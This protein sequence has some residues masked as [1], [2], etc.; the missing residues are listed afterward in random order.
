VEDTNGNLITGDNGRVI[1]VS[2]GSGTSTLQG[3]LTVGTVN[4]LATFGNLSYNVAESITLRFTAS[5]LSNATSSSVTVGPAAADRLAFTTQPG[6]ATRVGSILAV[7]PVIKSRDPFGNLST[8][9]LPAS[10]PLTIA[11]SSG[12]GLLLGTTTFDIGASSGNGIA[13]CTNLACTTAGTNKQLSAT[14][15][16]LTT[17]LSSSF[18]MGGVDPALGG[19]AISA[20]TAGA[21]YTTLSGPVYYEAASGDAGAGNVIL[22]AP[23]GFSFDTGGTAPTVIIAR[24]G[25][26]GGNSNNVDKVASG[27][28]VAIT[29][30]A[31]NQVTLT[32]TNASSG[33]VTC[34]LTWTNLRVRPNAG[35]PLASGVLT[36]GGTATLAAVIASNTTFGTLAEIA[37]AATRLAFTTQ[38]GSG[39]AGTT[40]SSQPVVRSR[41][42]FGNNSTSGLPASKMLSL[43]LSGGTGPLLGTTNVDIGTAASNGVAAFANLEIDS[44][45][46]NKQLTA[47]AIAMTNVLSSVFTIAPGSASKLTLQ[48]QPS[49]T[50]T[51]GV[52][53]A[54]QPVIRIEDG[55]GNLRTSDNS[56]VVTAMRGTGSSTLMGTTSTAA[57]NGIVTFTNLSYNVAETMTLNFASAGLSG[58]TSINVSV[59]PAAA[60]RLTIATQPSATATAGA[61]FAQQPVIRI[62]DQFGNL[63]ASDNTTVVTATRSAGSGTLQGTTN[64]TA[65][66]GI[67]T[68]TDLSHNVVTNITIQF[69]SGTLA[70]ATSSSISVGVAAAS[71]LGIQ[72]QPSGNATAGVIF[73]QQPVVRVEDPFGNL[74]TTDNSSVITAARVG[75]AGILQGTL[76]A[77]VSNGLASFTNLSHLVA[78][79]ITIQFSSGT[80]A[81]VTS[82]NVTVSA[83]AAARLT[84]QTQ[85]PGTATAGAVFAPQP[86]VRVEDQFGN[87]RSSDNSTVVSAAR[88]LGSASLQGTTSATA[89]GGVATFTSLSYTLAETINVAFSSGSLTG[90]ISS[91]VVV[92]AAAASRLT[93]LTQPSGVATAGV[94]FA[95]QPIVRIEDP[96]G[97]LRSG[98]N[99]TVVTAASSSGTGTLQGTTTATASSGVAS[100]SNLSYPV[101]ETMKILF[102]SGSLTNATSG[103][104][105]VSAGPFAKLQLLTPGETAAPGTAG[106]KTGTPSQQI[107]GTAFPAIV[108]AVDSFYNLVNTVNDTVALSSSDSAATLPAAT[109]LVAGT[110]NLAVTLNTTGSFTVTASDLS[111][112]SKTASTSPAISVGPAQFTSARP[113]SPWLPAAAPSQPTA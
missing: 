70:S 68:F 41:D 108:N 43:A 91:N 103:N 48:T 66:G 52:V 111:D 22:N 88:N 44:A 64:R 49:S 10:L 7:Q 79:N 2:V 40:L 3:T 59:I 36:A 86:Q 5:G 14:A 67:V 76:M 55:Y 112:N 101:A 27:M 102:S 12:S 63:R 98:D 97:N 61:A 51:A 74:M 46:T 32:V 26:T 75:G 110:A 17:G 28:A 45:G 20:D 107:V 65:L 6:G 73:N 87:L 30:R 62:E 80:L 34:S 58:A 93:I 8:I 77:T 19:G 16:G 50:A 57:V 53:F 37:G 95:Q 82:S 15:T 71:R 47:S 4:G 106:G 35:T 99:I 84:L 18:S 24:I 89:S 1:T 113:S 96:Y 39:T 23:A 90:T 105:V 56:T 33:G 25:G 85:P 83:A 100:F 72:T 94:A 21:G 92:S 31:T 60:S 104:V 81:S 109:A 29:S 9:G 78:T 13:I 69:T 11:L 42:Q 38:P 54:Q